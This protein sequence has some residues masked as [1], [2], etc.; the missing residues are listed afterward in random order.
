MTK[1]IKHKISYQKYLRVLN[2]PNRSEK[3]FKVMKNG[4]LATHC[5]W[6]FVSDGF[7][8][9]AVQDLY[10]PYIRNENPSHYR[11]DVAQAITQGGK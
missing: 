9:V 8:Y 10:K 3:T 2:H 4:N 5:V 1:P 6:S 7:V 11:Y